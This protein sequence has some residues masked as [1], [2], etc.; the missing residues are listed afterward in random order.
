MCVCARLPNDND[1][2]DDVHLPNPSENERRCSSDNV[3]V[4]TG[5]TRL[6]VSLRQYSNLQPPSLCVLYVDFHRILQELHFKTVDADRRSIVQHE[7][8]HAPLLHVY[9]AAPHNPHVP[10][11]ATV[12][13]LGMASS[14]IALPAYIHRTCVPRRCNRIYVWS[15]RLFKYKKM[16]Q[17]Y[18]LFS[19]NQRIPF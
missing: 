14:R 12:F 6:H 15:D 10:P 7:H 5:S 3:A 19:W 9:L 16:N 2:H 8:M 18:L 4:W 13:A 1:H 11:S 17:I